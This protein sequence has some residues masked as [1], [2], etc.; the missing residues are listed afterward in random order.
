MEEVEGSPTHPASSFAPGEE[1]A[2]CTQ[3]LSKE[4]NTPESEAAGFDRHALSFSP[5]AA[6][7][8]D[9][10]KNAKPGKARDSI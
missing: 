7:E 9:E 6:N 2:E 5:T 8:K 3:E 10:V 4:A 1:Q